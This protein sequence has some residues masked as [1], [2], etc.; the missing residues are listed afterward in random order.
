MSIKV[1]RITAIML[2]AAMLVNSSALFASAEDNNAVQNDSPD[3]LKPI[4][5]D[6]NELF[7]VSECD[8]DFNC[9]CLTNEIDD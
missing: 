6:N 9:L 1:K 4:C 3:P 5:I 7:S 8:S 2:A